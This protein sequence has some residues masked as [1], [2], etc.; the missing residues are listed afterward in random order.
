MRKTISD[1]TGKFNR[2]WNHGIK[3]QT[4]NLELKTI[5]NSVKN[6]IQ[7]TKSTM[8]Q[9]EEINLWSRRQVIWR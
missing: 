7:S 2:D 4:E 9:A 3:N 6:I 5:M 1:Q 8:D